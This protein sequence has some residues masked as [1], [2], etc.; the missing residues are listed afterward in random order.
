[1]SKQKENVPDYIL[2]HKK[3]YESS[4]VILDTLNQGL[5]IGY[6]KA[7]EKHLTEKDGKIHFKSLKDNKT[8]QEFVETMVDHYVSDAQKAL[9][10][11]GKLDQLEKDMLLN[12]YQGTTTGR[13]KQL[14]SQ[15]GAKFKHDVFKGLSGQMVKNVQ[16][17][18]YDSASAHLTQDHVGEIVKHVG[19]EG[20][21]DATK[22]TDKEAG[23][24]L[25]IFHED[26]AVPESKLDEIIASYKKVK[27][28]KAD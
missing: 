17:R 2:K 8:Q 7:V 21:V 13:L 19:L 4:D 18:L 9:K 27:K 26:G 1:M 25:E 23:K 6:T 28:E 5:M 22:V 20:I 15:Y 10:S 3:L 24:L 11:E 12:A 16:E 14:V